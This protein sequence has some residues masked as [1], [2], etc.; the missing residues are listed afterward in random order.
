MLITARNTIRI[1]NKNEKHTCTREPEY[2]LQKRAYDIFQTFGR[3]PKSKTRSRRHAFYLN[4]E[5]NQFITWI[6]NDKITVWKFRHETLRQN[7]VLEYRKQQ[8]DTPTVVHNDDWIARPPNTIYIIRHTQI[9][10][11]F[12]RC[13]LFI[14][15]YIKK[16]K[17][18]GH[19]AHTD[20]IALD[21][22]CAAMR[23]L[24]HFII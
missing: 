23:V 8:R 21:R 12:F 22:R 2:I 18:N 15:M 9:A 10:S 20:I 16:N 6:I 11:T 4:V 19:N 3:G 7:F 17:K 1:P 24:L 13:V 14:Y 5:T